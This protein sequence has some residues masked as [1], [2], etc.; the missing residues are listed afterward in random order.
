MFI[1]LTLNCL[2]CAGK[3]GRAKRIGK[4]KHLNWQHVAQ[5]LLQKSGVLKAKTIFWYFCTSFIKKTPALYPKE[6][7]WNIFGKFHNV[8]YSQTSQNIFV[9]LEISPKLTSNDNLC[10]VKF[11]TGFRNRVYCIKIQINFFMR[12]Y[13]FKATSKIHHNDLG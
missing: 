6:P 8:C 9:Q 5:Y 13:P 7:L 2:L 12:K 3:L 1:S 4:H 11:D 10:A